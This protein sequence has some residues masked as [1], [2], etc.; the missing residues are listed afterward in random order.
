[1]IENDSGKLEPWTV[2][3]KPDSPLEKAN[4]AAEMG[5]EDENGEDGGSDLYHDIWVSSDFHFSPLAAD[6]VPAQGSI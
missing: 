5:L 1:M 4:L 3:S 2:I 6:V